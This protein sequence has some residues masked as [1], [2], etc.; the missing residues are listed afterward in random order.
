[1]QKLFQYRIKINIKKE[2]KNEKKIN[3]GQLGR[4]GR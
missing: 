1:M 3:I 4:Q 2:E